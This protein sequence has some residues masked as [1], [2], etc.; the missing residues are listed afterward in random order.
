MAPAQAALA[1]RL[2]RSGSFY[3]ALGRAIKVIRTEQGLE[4]KELARLSGLSYPYLSEIEQGKK[5]PSSESLQAIA[6]SL[7]L[8]QSELLE[9]AE[10]SLEASQALAGLPA[11]PRRRSRPSKARAYGRVY[12]LPPAASASL[13]KEELQEL[14]SRAAQLGADDFHR[15]LDLVRRLTR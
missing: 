7:R 11:A 2:Q 5:R 9:R 1:G 12:R 6:R 10:R 13:F 15:V 4:R 8:R 3:P 14:A